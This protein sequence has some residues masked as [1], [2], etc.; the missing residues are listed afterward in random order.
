MPSGEA[1]CVPVHVVSSR[2]T[3]VRLAQ[4]VAGKWLT[5]SENTLINPGLPTSAYIL[6]LRTNNSAPSRR[7][8]RVYMH[9]RWPEHGTRDTSSFARIP[10]SGRQH[11]SKRQG[12]CCDAA[13]RE[14]E[15]HVEGPGTK[16]G[17]VAV[18]PPH[19]Q[20]LVGFTCRFVD[21][22]TPPGS[23]GRFHMLMAEL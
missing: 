16:Q 18:L 6:Y 3:R 23:N 14:P 8:A 20:S 15:S 11:L 17:S 7:C 4:T 5:D 1:T 13:I 22:N 9:R 21:G 10:C 2:R 12:L 19:D